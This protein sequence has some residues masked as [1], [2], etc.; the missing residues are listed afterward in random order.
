MT[1]NAKTQKSWP[2]LVRTVYNKAV[3]LPVWQI[4]DN[5]CFLQALYVIVM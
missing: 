5:I 1:A 2:Q 3:T 4:C